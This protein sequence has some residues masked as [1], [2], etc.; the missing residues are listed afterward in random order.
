VASGGVLAAMI[1][2]AP[3]RNRPEQAGDCRVIALRVP[4]LEAQRHLVLCPAGS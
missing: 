4:L 3:Y 2:A 1:G